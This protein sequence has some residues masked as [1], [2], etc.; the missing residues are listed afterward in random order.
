[1]KKTMRASQV[2][3][4]VEF[5]EQFLIFFS[6]FKTEDQFKRLNKQ[7]ETILQRVKILV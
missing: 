7:M 6:D 3:L 4:N 1:M 5:Y 2:K